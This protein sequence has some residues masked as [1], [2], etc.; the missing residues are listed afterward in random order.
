MLLVDGMYGPEEG[1]IDASRFQVYRAKV[2]SL[3][4]LG[5]GFEAYQ[6]TDL[7]ERAF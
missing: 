3:L 7:T 5:F 6:L 2:K 1:D 4:D